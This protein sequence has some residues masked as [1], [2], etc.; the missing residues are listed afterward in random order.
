MSFG[1]PVCPARRHV[2]RRALFSA[3]CLAAL[4]ALTIRDA[5]AQATFNR[6][7]AFGDSLSDNGNLFAASGGTV[8]VS[9][10]YFQGRLSNGPV[11]VE[12]LATAF[13]VPLNDFAVAG[14]RTDATNLSNTFPGVPPNTFPGMQTQV[15]GFLAV[16]GGVADPNALYTVWGGANDY[17]NGGQLDPA[18]PVGNITAQLNA[19]ANAGARQFLVPNLPNLGSVPGTNGTP[20]S[21]GLNLLTAGHNQAL[22]VALNNFRQ[23]RPNVSVALLDVNTLFVQVIANG[24]AFGFDNVTQNYVSSQGQVQGLN[25]VVIGTGDPNRYLFW[26]EVH[27]TGAAHQ[28]VA[29]RAI[30]A[31]TA[32]EPGTLALLVV[33]LVGGP[34]AR[35][36]ARGRRRK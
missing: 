33:G 20:L 31:V 11:W 21:A 29:N 22:A 1:T 13:G 7:I 2:L 14:A 3:L 5:A 28:Q 6:V 25:P 10:P 32:P 9:P 17:L 26:D 30:A 23:A 27:P 34:L 36:S 15:N 16:N 24:A 4:P 12:R 19:L 8:P 18:V 35:R